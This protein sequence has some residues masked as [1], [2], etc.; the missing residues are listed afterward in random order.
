MIYR[1]HNKKITGPPSSQHELITQKLPLMSYKQ[2]HNS[3][4][5]TSFSRYLS[6]EPVEPMARS[7]TWE[8]LPT[9]TRYIKKQL[10]TSSTR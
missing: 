5:K 8:R 7:I 4:P 2:N 10:H 9:L 6:H 3:V 1:S